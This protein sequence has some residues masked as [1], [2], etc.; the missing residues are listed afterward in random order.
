[1]RLHLPIG[2]ALVAGLSCQAGLAPLEDV[3]VNRQLA[4]A[5]DPYLYELVAGAKEDVVG[6]V[7]VW[8]DAA[9]LTVSLHVSVGLGLE[10][11]HLCVAEAPFPWT[12]PGLC[13]HH[14]ADL[15]GAASAAFTVELA[16]IGDDLCDEVIHLQVH[17]DVGDAE[18]EILGAY[19]GAF[20]GS[21]AYT[22]G[23][24]AP[25]AE[26]T[27]TRSHGYWKHHEWPV[28][29]LTIGGERYDRDALL[30]LLTSPARG[31][32][33]VILGRQLVA[34]LLNV[35][36]GARTTHDVDQA[37]AAAHAW[38]A[39]LGGRLP[40]GLRAAPGDE[41]NAAAFDQAISLAAILD[42]YNNGEVGPGHCPD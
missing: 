10:L 9:R 19:A 23:C 25:P 12:P 36:A 3:R 32:G 21:V 37:I 40:H 18:G 31:D 35:A 2:L 4:T 26:D 17:A 15:G 1:M 8:N 6:E 28:E 27:C 34:A 20:K 39:G 42:R 41:P 33:S 22:V 14:L 24:D 30:A 11:A 38:A 5:E 7:R 16:E 29:T 13:A